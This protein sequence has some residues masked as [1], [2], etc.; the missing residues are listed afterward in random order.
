MET[1]YIEIGAFEAKTKLGELLERASRGAAFTITKHDR[2]VARLVGFVAD[3]EERRQE[4][5][6]TLK[7]LR[8]RYS[9]NGLDA[10]ALRE[11]GRA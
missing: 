1:S 7:R 10:R 5:T 8:A 11:E 6:E 4:A 9:L 3:R 2:P